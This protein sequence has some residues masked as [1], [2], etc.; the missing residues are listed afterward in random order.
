MADNIFPEENQNKIYAAFA[1]IEAEVVGYGVHEWY[2][3]LL[4]Q[5]REKYLIW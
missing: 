1:Q 4:N 3:H 5:L 2:H